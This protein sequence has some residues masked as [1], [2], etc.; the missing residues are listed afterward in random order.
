MT[1]LLIAMLAV[2]VVDGA[3]KRVLRRRMVQE[4]LSLGAYGSIR[5]V[6]HQ[7]WLSRIQPASLAAT[8]ALLVLAV[9]PLFVLGVV[10]PSSAVFVG[11]AV[12]GAL[13]N[14]LEHAARGSVSDYICLRF[15]PAFNLGD[16]AITVGAIGIAT[17]LW[18]LA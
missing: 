9:V 8:S 13:S 17:T 14:W 16:A 5:I 18:R 10:V 6:R 7:L 2:P 15:W 12:G 11:L 3:I 4:P 1:E